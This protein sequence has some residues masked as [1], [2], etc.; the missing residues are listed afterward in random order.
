MNTPTSLDPEGRE[1]AR[2]A[3]R[4]C[5]AVQPSD[6]VF[7]IT[8]EE[9]MAVGAALLAEAQAITQETRLITLE[10]VGT[11]PLLALPVP[12]QTALRDFKPTVTF[13]AAQ[14]Q[15]G[16]IAFRLLLRPFSLKELGTGAR[17][18]HMIGISPELM[19]DGMRGDYQQIAA[20]TRAV[21]EKARRARQMQVTSRKGTDLAVQFD[22]LLKWVPCTGLYHKPGEWGNL[23][24]GETYTSPARADGVLVADELGDHFSARYGVLA[25]P[26]TF[27]LENGWV[28]GV[29]CADEGIRRE[30]WDYLNSA[31]NGRRAG[32]F[33]IGTNVGLTRLTGNLLQDEKIPGIHVA[34]GNPYPEMTGAQWSSRVHVDVIPTECTIDVD[35]E[36]LMTAGRFHL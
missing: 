30:V 8:D 25:T 17:H 14:G 21:W 19:R 34:F 18:G 13:F 3:V 11:R 32:E 24:E 9:T 2:V 16:E 36:R 27:H 15:P 12:L 31:E 1:G 22:P 33:A 35:G 5:M 23:P 10:E 29:E 7:I 28:T 20:V 6:R 4:T 26:V